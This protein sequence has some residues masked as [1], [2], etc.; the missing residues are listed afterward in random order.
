MRKRLVWRLAAAA[1]TEAVWALTIVIRKVY[2]AAYK[3]YIGL[4]TLRLEANPLR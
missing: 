1:T 3:E 2:A 4:D